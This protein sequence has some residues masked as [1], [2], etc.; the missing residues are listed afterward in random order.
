MHPCLTSDIDRCK[1]TPMAEHLVTSK[2]TPDSLHM[3]RMV[4]AKTG[5]KQYEVVRRLLE[6]EMQRLSLT[7]ERR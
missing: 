3:V 6:A 4:A 5:E 2:I 7:A 1:F